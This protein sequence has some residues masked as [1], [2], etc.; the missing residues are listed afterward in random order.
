MSDYGR[1]RVCIAD[2]E[3]RE[4]RGQMNVKKLFMILVLA[5]V[6]MLPA[7]VQAQSSQ[8]LQSLPQSVSTQDNLLARVNGSEVR[9][10][11]V[12]RMLEQLPAEVR[13]MP[14]GQLF[15][16]LIE[17]AVD[18]VLVIQAARTEGMADDPEIRAR[19]K[20]VEDDLLWARFLES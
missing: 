7:I 12:L 14:Q 20:Q 9:Q 17:R 13:N 19:V 18:R 1:A 16:L 3:V 15:T 2:D 11:D 4:A 8:P 6:M 5:M 10:S